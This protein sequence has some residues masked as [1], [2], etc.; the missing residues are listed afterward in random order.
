METAVPEGRLLSCALLLDIVD[1]YGGSIMEM[2][3]NEFLA[4]IN[5]IAMRKGITGI[6]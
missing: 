5:G 1:R 2:K 3:R 6:I 4:T